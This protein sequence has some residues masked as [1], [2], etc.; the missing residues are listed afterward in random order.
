MEESLEA[1]FV[2][3]VSEST[4]SIMILLASL[5]QRQKLGEKT[6]IL[7]KYIYFDF[8]LKYKITMYSL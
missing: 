1:K 3:F 7:F 4:C 6:K 8:F 2:N 5:L